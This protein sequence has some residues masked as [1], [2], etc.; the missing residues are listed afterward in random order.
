MAWTCA[1]ASVD[2]LEHR[3]ILGETPLRERRACLATLH[4][5][6]EQLARVGINRNLHAKT[7]YGT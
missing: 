3:P 1:H 6:P 5:L 7:K 2:D 4:P